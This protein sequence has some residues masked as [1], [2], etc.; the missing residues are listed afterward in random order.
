MSNKSILITGGLGYIGSH[1]SIELI[2]AGYKIVIIDN[3]SNSSIESL[4]RMKKLVQYNIPFYNIDIRDKDKLDQVFRENKIDGVIHFAGLKSVNEST[5][6]PLE[7]Y[8][9]NVNGTLAL[10]QVMKSNNCKKFVFSSSATVYGN[11]SSLPIIENSPLSATNPYGR[12][13]LVIEEILQDLFKSDHNWRIAILR[14]FNPVGAHKSSVIGENPNGIPN[15]LMPYIAQVAVGKLKILKV[16]GGD[17]ET[18]DGTGIRDYIHITDLAKGHI[19]ALN[20]LIRKPQILIANLGTGTGYSVLEMIK[21]FEVVSGCQIPY[22][23]IGRRPG[24]I[25][26]CYSD[27]TFAKKSI[28]WE[29]HLSLSEMCEDTWKWQSLNPSGF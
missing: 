25:A 13:K 3:L 6:K 5:I 9:N 24:D 22:E 17:Y 21:A 7:Y 19:K 27:V 2:D 10:I 14:Y 15:N 1:T 23:I 4:R 18:P 12:S 8:D 26:E 28:D 16:F 29:T 11:P 20:A